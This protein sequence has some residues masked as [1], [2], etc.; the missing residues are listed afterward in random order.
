MQSPVINHTLPSVLLAGVH[1]SK[2]MSALHVSTI[3]ELRKV[4]VDKLVDYTSGSRVVDDG[5]FFQNG[6]S[7]E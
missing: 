7:T 1:L 6:S 4:P 5:Y 2:V 3:H